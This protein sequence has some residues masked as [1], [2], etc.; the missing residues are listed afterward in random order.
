MPL[1]NPHLCLEKENCCLASQPRLAGVC[2]SPGWNVCVCVYLFL[3]VLFFKLWWRGCLGSYLTLGVDIWRLKKEFAVDF[4]QNCK[5][6]YQ[7]GNRAGERSAEAGFP[8]WRLEA[9]ESVEEASAQD[10]T[11][12]GGWGPSRPS[13]PAQ[14][15]LVP[16]FR[17]NT[18]ENSCCNEV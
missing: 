13:S 11:P 15:S 17:F 10:H 4:I 16:K 1:G 18:F 3:Y 8:F 5:C 14:S 2:I 9:T 12:G 6:V 7:P